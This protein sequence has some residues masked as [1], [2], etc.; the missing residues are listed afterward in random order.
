M[1]NINKRVW[2]I[3]AMDVCAQRDLTRKLINIRGLAKYIIKNHLPDASIDSVISA[4]RRFDAQKFTDSREYKEIFK[5][6]I[7]STKNFLACVTTKRKAFRHLAKIMEANFDKKGAI[8]LIRGE[9]VSKIIVDQHNLEE[10]LSFLPDPEISKVEKDLGEI[11][12]NLSPK[13]EETPGV[14]ARIVNEIAIHDININEIIISLPEV[15]IFVSQD[16]LLRV[17][18]IVFGLTTTK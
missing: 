1:T 18:E 12:I 8:R 3:L 9:N 2:E 6:A 11:S 7:V 16:D 14:L 13:A 5:D 17:H 15:R 10:L 4:I